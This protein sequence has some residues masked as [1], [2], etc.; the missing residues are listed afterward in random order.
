MLFFAGMSLR[1][2]WQPLRVIV[3]ALASIMLVVGVVVVATLPVS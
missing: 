2:L 1:V 3:L